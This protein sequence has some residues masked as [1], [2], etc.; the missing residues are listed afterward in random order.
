[1]A[2]SD[3]LQRWPGRLIAAGRALA[4]L[5]VRDLA[6]A[7][8]VTPRTIV[9]IEAMDVVLVSP[10]HRHGAVSAETWD[11][12]TGALARDVEL[13]PARGGHGAGVRFRESG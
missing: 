5:T 8:G 12:I 9:R 1:M 13:L 7:A 2:D 4:G 6:A 3:D 11:K 10:V